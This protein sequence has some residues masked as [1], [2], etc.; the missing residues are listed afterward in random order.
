MT[1]YT[2]FFQHLFGMEV[3]IPGRSIV[4]GRGSGK[5]LV[6]PVPISFLSGVDPETGIIIEEN[7][8]LQG[9]TVEGKIL[10]FPFGKG[11]TV[12]SYVMYA[13]KRNGKAPAA[14]INEEVEPIIAVGAII[15]GIPMIDRT[16]IPLSRLQTGEMATVD[17]DTGELR[18]EES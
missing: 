12:G 9:E 8:P 10:V 2:W 16:A 15:A 6:S 18:I 3:I 1:I 5:L 17:G 11:S 7:H 4:K 13:L 14:I